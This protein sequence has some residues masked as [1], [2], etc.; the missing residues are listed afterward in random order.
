MEQQTW[1]AIFPQPLCSGHVVQLNMKLVYRK[2][3]VARSRVFCKDAMQ[4]RRASS[5]FVRMMVTEM[6]RGED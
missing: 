5:I 2:G 3:Q 1:T 6:G 4:K